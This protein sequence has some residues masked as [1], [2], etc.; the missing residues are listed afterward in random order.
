MAHQKR[1]IGIDQGTTSTK[2]LVLSED[3]SIDASFNKEHKQITPKPGWI[4]HNGDE[5][6]KNICDAIDHVGDIAA[7]G[8]DHQ[9]ES[10]IAWNAETKET[11][12]NVIVWQDARTKKWL[13]EL[14]KDGVEEWVMK[15]TG[16]PLDPYFPASK[17]RWLLKNIPAVKN[18]HKAGKLRMGTMNSFFIDRLTGIYSTDYNSASRTSLFNIQT[19]QWDEE[20]CRL[21][22]IPMEILPPIV[23]NI[24]DFGSYN[25]I[26]ITATI[27]D[28]FA[29]IYGHGCRHAGDAK[30][31][32]GTGAF[33]QSLTGK[34]FI[35]DKKSGLLPALCWK[36][37]NEEPMFGLDGG[38]YNAASAI[39][40]V[41]KIG[42]FKEY[43][44]INHFE[45]NHAIARNIVFVPALSG[46]ACPH[47]DRTA[48][49]I[50][51]GLS[52]NTEKEDMIQA[53]LEGIALRAAEVLE[54]MDK[55]F[56]LKD[57]LSMDG[58]VS[59]NPYFRQFFA[60]MAQKDITIPKNQ[61]LS[62]YGVALLARKGLGYEEIQSSNDNETIIHPNHHIA[63]KDYKK[64][65]AA[66]VA[67]AKAT[68][69]VKT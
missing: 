66:I 11:L 31:T 1:F 45:N 37:D 61:E 21:F 42:L 63:A 51:T 22:E 47:W 34:E 52:L 48:S 8:L 56:A 36:F 67:K 60:D 16:L 33:I 58:G 23:A 39:N 26:P 62:S 54:A 14:K 49:G 68:I 50:W 6:F 64:Q 44:K 53:V 28:Q 3:G 32:F 18:C 46:L 30:V 25:N 27:I 41:K 69:S 10:I 19:L 15:K 38:V 43:S 17:M 20:L 9:G 12:Y 2:I 40:W 29:G 65:F 5:I 24:A 7:M 59:H 57:R 4:E 35:H 13:Q 55:V